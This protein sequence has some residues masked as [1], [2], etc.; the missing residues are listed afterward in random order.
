[1]DLATGSDSI[2]SKA[3]SFIS[4]VMLVIT[5]RATVVTVN[6]R[7]PLPMNSAWICA[8]S[9][10]ARSPTNSVRPNRQIR[11]ITDRPNTLLRN[12]SRNV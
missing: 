5:N 2:S 11:P 1:M 4:R 10:M 3:L 6:R 12:P 7:M 9:M 8:D